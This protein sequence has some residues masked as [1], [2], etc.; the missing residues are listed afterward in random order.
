M[1]NTESVCRALECFCPTVNGD[2]RTD[3]GLHLGYWV[4]KEE[5]GSFPL[6]F[7]IAIVTWSSA[8]QFA[9]SF[10]IFPYGDR[11]G[12]DN[13]FQIGG[14]ISKDEFA[15]ENGMLSAVV[16]HQSG[17]WLPGQGFFDLAKKAWT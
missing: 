1:L 16:V 10:H 13:I 12:R 8:F 4:R 17:D 15:S 2:L 14:E 7:G 9:S 3:R 5:R 11:R 6:F